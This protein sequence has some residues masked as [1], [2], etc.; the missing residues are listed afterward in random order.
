MDIEHIAAAP[1]TQKSWL[2]FVSL[3]S[4]PTSQLATRL[5]ARMQVVGQ[6]DKIVKRRY[7]TR[8]HAT[9]DRLDSK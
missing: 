2:M 1:A 8:W 7:Q 4:T 6:D 5:L 3:L 9:L